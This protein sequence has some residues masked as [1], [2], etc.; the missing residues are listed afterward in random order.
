[1]KK[2]KV[3]AM[4]ALSAAVFAGLGSAAEAA[5]FD[6][7]ATYKIV[8]QGSG[9]VLDVEHNSVESGS[10]IHQWTYMGLPSQHWKLKP[11]LDGYY[12]LINVNSGLAAYPTGSSNGSRAFQ[13][14]FDNR[15]SEKWDIQDFGT[16]YKI[17]SKPYGKVLDIQFN[18]VDNGGKVHIWQ[19]L[20]GISTQVWNIVPL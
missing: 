3:F 12:Y 6:P 11:T 14:F 2:A 16:G 7:N 18:T 8:N 13:A 10:G 9:K 1:M 15:E 20:S 4:M 5:T 17:A 19:T